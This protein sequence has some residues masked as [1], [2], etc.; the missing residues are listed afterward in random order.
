[1]SVMHGNFPATGQQHL[2]ARAAVLGDPDLVLAIF[3]FLDISSICK[4][5]RSCKLWKDTCRAQGIWVEAIFLERNLGTNQI[6]LVCEKYH[7]TIQRLVLRLER[8]QYLRDFLG[9]RNS[10]HLPLESL[11]MLHLHG[12][13]LESHTSAVSSDHMPHLS[14]LVLTSCEAPRKTLGVHGQTVERLPI[15]IFHEKLRVAIILD[16]S[17]S[18]LV[19]HCPLL[20]QLSISHV[21][22]FKSFVFLGSF[23]SLQGLAM[24]H[25]NLPDDMLGKLLSGFSHL[26]DLDLSGTR[27]TS[28]TLNMV[29]HNNAATLVRL[30]VKDCPSLTQLHVVGLTSVRTPL[31]CNER[32]KQAISSS[33][34]TT[35]SS[36]AAGGIVLDYQGSV[37]MCGAA[38]T[39]SSVVTSTA[40]Q[41]PRC[42][43][44]L[45]MDDCSKLVV[46]SLHDHPRLRLVSLRACTSLK[47][48][49]L[50]CP[51]LEQLQLGPCGVS[52]TG[53]KTISRFSPEHRRQGVSLKALVKQQ[54][55]QS[56][57]APITA[58][59]AVE[60]DAAAATSTATT[61]TAARATT[62]AALAAITAMGAEEF[63]SDD[64]P[65][66]PPPLPFVEDHDHHD[67]LLLLPLG[68]DQDVPDILL[69]PGNGGH[70]GHQHHNPGHQH[71]LGHQHHNPGHQYHPGHQH[72]LGHHNGLHGHH[73]HHHHHFGGANI[74]DPQLPQPA[75]ASS[76]QLELLRELA[77]AYGNH[78]PPFM[79]QVL[80]MRHHHFQP[81]VLPPAPP[82]LPV[83]LPPP[84]L[85]QLPPTTAGAAA[86]NASTTSTVL[87]SSSDPAG[88]SSASVPLHYHDD[89]AHDSH[90]Y[91]Q[92]CCRDHNGAA[93]SGGSD[94]KESPT[95]GG[96]GGDMDHHPCTH[97]D[98]STSW[99]SLASLTF[100]SCWPQAGTSNKSLRR[101]VVCSS[102][103][104]KLELRHM[105]HLSELSLECPQLEHLS[106]DDCDSLGDDVNFVMS[107]TSAAATS[108]GI[109]TTAI[110]PL[111]GMTKMMTHHHHPHEDTR[112]SS[113]ST[114]TAATSSL[115]TLPK[116][117]ELRIERCDGF[118]RLVLQYPLLQ[119]LCVKDCRGLQSMLLSC[120]EL[121]AMDLEGCNKLHTLVMQLVAIE[122][123]ILGTAVACSNLRSLTV[124]SD[125][126]RRLDLKGCKKLRT[127]ALPYCPSL[128]SLDASF[129]DQVELIAAACHEHEAGLHHDDFNHKSNSTAV[130]KVQPAAAA[131]G[132]LSSPPT[133]LDDV[134]QQPAL[135]L[136]SHQPQL[137]HLLLS[138]CLDINKTWLPG[139]SST[140]MKHIRVADLSYTDVADLGP[141]FRSCPRLVSL[142]LN[143]CRNLQPL[144]LLDAFPLC[145]PEISEKHR[146]YSVQDDK[147]ACLFKLSPLSS[148]SSVGGLLPFLQDLDISYCN[149]FTLQHLVTLMMRGSSSLST[150]GLCGLHAVQSELFNI[151][152]H[153]ASSIMEGHHHG[154]V[155]SEGHHDCH[156]SL[157]SAAS[158]PLRADLDLN[159]DDDRLR[160]DL[161]RSGKPWSAVLSKL[162]TLNMVGCKS[163][164]TLM[165]GLSLKDMGVLRTRTLLAA[166]KDTAV[167]QSLSMTW[168]EDHSTCFKDL[169]TLKLGLSGVQVLALRLPQLTYLDMSGAEDIH[170]LELRCPLLLTLLHT[171]GC[172]FKVTAPYCPITARRKTKR[173][174]KTMLSAQRAKSETIDDDMVH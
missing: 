153:S 35:S 119:D 45:H 25:H 19:L 12:C 21:P 57:V 168:V 117:K 85:P 88:A 44:E 14:K 63:D 136:P 43:E 148:A 31:L 107:N 52:T 97:Q 159:D 20:T 172:A 53:Q 23:S 96:G 146:N 143:S 126:L 29:A 74:S 41:F 48:L 156:V 42:L 58:D 33:S 132:P 161:G 93:G 6:Q 142:N 89:H 7:K 129:C 4:A 59:A 92:G 51:A 87:S 5:A 17:F 101:L 3:K 8:N 39:A 38:S 137:N 73:H 2:A 164:K 54:L 90:D 49:S 116:L 138:A 70:L 98:Y 18:F 11:R 15:H 115:L 174:I 112:L 61:A 65:F 147:G 131:A 170:T 145:P 56:G 84:L 163:L 46:V 171:Q 77:R 155:V 113:S 158:L 108:S 152:K 81:P 141:L 16:C 36:D 100:P 105:P 151:I 79:R 121:C 123:I 124:A 30:D 133:A 80:T 102:S 82:P 10:A 173:D 130:V 22:D 76:E 34:T 149:S 9:K 72:H 69:N 104:T 28:E 127:L 32:D 27:I 160:R 24:S 47:N 154:A 135:L 111:T 64:D 103:L 86:N 110:A 109:V 83:R 125:K 120:Q 157:S 94:D 50:Y 162:K 167:L 122:N 78:P 128:E 91:Q 99:A 75:I 66:W 71:H 95:V 26:T 166:E 144:S 37:N 150:L 140:L 60:T 106:L 165:L 40:F 114:T 55:V 139:L 1:M 118:S 134:E 67:E 169:L 68:M 62:A 13:L